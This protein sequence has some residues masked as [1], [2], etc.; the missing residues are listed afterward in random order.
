MPVLL[1]RTKWGFFLL[2][3]YVEFT[4][5]GTSTKS[6]SEEPDSGPYYTHLGAAASMPDMRSRL[7]G[8]I[9]CSAEQLRIE[10]ARFVP[11]A[12]KGKYGCPVA[13]YVSVRN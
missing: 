3:L 4:V 9:G 10:R 13:K 8:Q 5:L 12:G 1:L 11:R 6:I 7:L 2:P